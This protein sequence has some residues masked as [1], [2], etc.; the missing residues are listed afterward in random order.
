MQPLYNKVML[1]DEEIL[2]YWD[3]SR[4][5]AVC[6]TN[7]LMQPL[8]NK[9]LLPGQEILEYW[10]ASREAVVGVLRGSGFDGNEE[11]AQRASAG[12]F[13]LRFWVRL[14]LFF[15]MFCCWC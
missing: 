6:T 13:L 5:E 8:Y 4:E 14:L 11:V 12:T 10:D 7:I 9:V 3:A 1:P 15:C 2:E